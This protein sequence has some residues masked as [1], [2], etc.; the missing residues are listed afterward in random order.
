M[1]ARYT[2]V[3]KGT[4]LDSRSSHALM[5]A[6]EFFPGASAS[7]CP[8]SLNT[9]RAT[10]FSAASTTGVKRARHTTDQDSSGKD[11]LM[12]F[13]HNATNRSLSLSH[14]NRRTLDL[15]E[16]YQNFDK[17]ADPEPR[18]IPSRKGAAPVSVVSKSIRVI[19]TPGLG[20]TQVI[21]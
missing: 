5:N 20:L 9:L 11:R 6:A 19:T 13:S 15:E 2:N 1:Q 10:R 14:Q 21:W 7:T 18:V 12:R 8:S 16:L 3:V 4:A 17:A